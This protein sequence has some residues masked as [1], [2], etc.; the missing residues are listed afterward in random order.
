MPCRFC[1]ALLY[2][3]E[4]PT[5]ISLIISGS[6]RLEISL[7]VLYKEIKEG[8]KTQTVYVLNY[9][10]DEGK[11]ETMFAMQFATNTWTYD[12]PNKTD[13]I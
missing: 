1:P 6:L 13:P 7:E 9:E 3:E 5:E 2:I 10:H 11:N 8:E 4:K 12:D